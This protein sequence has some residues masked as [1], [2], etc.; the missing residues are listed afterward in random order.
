MELPSGRRGRIRY[1]PTGDP[2]LSA[3][4]Q[5][6]FGLDEV[7]TICGGRAV[8]VVEI[9]APNS[10]PVQTTKDLPGFW[11]DTYPKIRQELRRR[12][13]KHEWR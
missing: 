4:I 8:P 6:L 7:P 1:G 10:R 2:V 5:D 12:Y 3:R 11:R 13:P 9:L